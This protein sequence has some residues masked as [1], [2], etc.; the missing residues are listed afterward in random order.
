M[1]IS[2]MKKLRDFL[3]EKV[4]DEIPEVT[5]MVILI[6]RL[7]NNA[8]FTFLGVNGEDLIESNLMSMELQHLLVLHVL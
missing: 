6:S 1:K 2:H 4:L 3:V 7:P 5:L 8:H